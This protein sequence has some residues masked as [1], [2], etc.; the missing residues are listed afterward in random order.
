MIHIVISSSKFVGEHRKATDVPIIFGKRN[1]R[2]QENIPHTS[3]NPAATDRVSHTG[4]E[5]EIRTPE[6]R[7][8][9]LAFQASAFDHSA[10][11]PKIRTHFWSS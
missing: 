8:G 10:T 1:R 9:L 7:E 5:G 3:E 4:G 6:T 2:L 11:S